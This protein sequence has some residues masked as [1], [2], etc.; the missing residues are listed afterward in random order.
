MKKH[1]FE[2]NLKKLLKLLKLKKLL[3]NRP[4]VGIFCGII[5][6][7]FAY[8][9]PTMAEFGP[10]GHK[11]F[12]LGQKFYFLTKIFLFQNVIF[13]VFINSIDFLSNFAEMVTEYGSLFYKIK[14][15]MKFSTKF[16]NSMLF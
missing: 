12:T 10:Q 11:I 1:N 16:K 14:E 4:I 2:N 7:N 6:Q 3:K 8:F 13:V 5:Y 15:N 9:W